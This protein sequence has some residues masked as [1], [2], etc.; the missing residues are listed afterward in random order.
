MRETAIQVILLEFIGPGDIVGFCEVMGLFRSRETYL[1]VTR[2]VTAECRCA[3]AWGT[4]QEE[5]GKSVGFGLV[6][7]FTW[8]T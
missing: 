6:Q 7:N 8:H 5:V 2:K 1:R 3:T 4:Y